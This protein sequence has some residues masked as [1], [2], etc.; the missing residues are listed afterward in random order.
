[1]D[2]ISKK[3]NEIDLQLNI[4][5]P[6]KQ[7]IFFDGQIFDAYTLA[8]DIIK[9]ATKSVIV[10]DNYIDE[11]VLT[12]LSKRNQNVVASIYTKPSKQL[13][14]DIDKHNQ[15]YPQIQIKSLTKSHDRFIILDQK[16]VYH[17]G[18]SLK[19]L[20]KKWFAFSKM[21]MDAK[22]ILRRLEN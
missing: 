19:D 11:T 12:L 21:E 5:L 6:T 3:V 8:C 7:G 15:Q 16:V 10:I 9:Q 2:A 20:G 18:A 17:L 22:E 14:L 4:N 13:K 1:M